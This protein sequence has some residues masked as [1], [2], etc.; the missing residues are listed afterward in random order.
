MPADLFGSLFPAAAEPVLSVGQL[1]AEIKD[2]LESS[3][4]S[5]WV[6]GEISNLSRPQSGHCYLTL[7][8]ESA[9]L[10]AVL[11]RTAASRV[12]FDLDDGLE[13]ICQGHLDLYAPRGS[14]Q[15]V[16]EQILPKGMG[17]LE[18]ALRKLRQ[19]L[20]AEGLFAPERKR[21]LPRFPREIAIVTS[22]TGAALR[23][24]LEVL[25]RRWRGTDVLVLPARVQGEGAA[26]EIAAAIAA[27][28]RLARPIDVL[29][30]ARGGGSLEDLW[31]F[32]EEV[33]V[34][35]IHGSRIP[36]VSAIG[37][38]IDVTLSDLVA[39]VRALTPSE[40]AELVVPSREELLAD[41]VR[42]ERRLAAS[43]RAR[44]AEA[45]GRLEVLGGSM[46]FRR[47]TARLHDLAR[48]VD[49]L[50]QRAERAVA[51]Q[52]Q[53]SR[54][55]WEAK[56]VHL[57]SLSPLAILTRGYSLTRRRSDGLSIRSADMLAPGD[58]IV[59]R[60][61]RGEVVSEVLRLES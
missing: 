53:R 60:F 23:D 17:A 52:L 33:V 6:S 9:Q 31:A 48:R 61:A 22:P 5:V 41:L 18:L 3:F 49:E 58:E 47:P 54:S 46:V 26:A 29:V 21:P 56:G 8:D 10:R 2:V 12:R 44:A 36:V 42:H 25:R 55:L 57:E 20:A 45:R 28:N 24:F 34:R 43:L 40:A 16:I 19:R 51:G 4:A 35:A 37:H 1:T 32:N 50:G 15:L 38:E 30:V 27:A 59:T 13:V 11:W 14:Y 39:D 7:K